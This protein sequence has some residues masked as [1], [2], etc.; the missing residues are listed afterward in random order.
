MSHLKITR[1]K[2]WKQMSGKIYQA[3]ANQNKTKWANS[4]NNNN[5]KLDRNSKENKIDLYEKPARNNYNKDIFRVTKRN[6][7]LRRYFW[8][9]RPKKQPTKAKSKK[10]KDANVHGNSISKYCAHLPESTT[11]VLKE[12]CPLLFMLIVF[13]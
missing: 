13:A 9:W 1:Q 12:T 10:G 3:Y 8:K 4:N 7:A 2:C 11:Y 5:N 6:Q